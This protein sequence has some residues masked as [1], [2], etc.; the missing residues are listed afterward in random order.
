MLTLR[1]IFSDGNETKTIAVHVFQ[2][3]KD[4]FSAWVTGRNLILEKT[5]AMGLCFK[6]IVRVS[7]NYFTHIL[8]CMCNVTK[9]LLVEIIDF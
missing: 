1:C 8:K 4:P 2:Q 5:K 7:Y 3:V 9:F 6:R